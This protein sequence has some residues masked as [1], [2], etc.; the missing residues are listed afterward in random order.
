M[1]L[2][3]MNQCGPNDVVSKG[4]YKRD[5]ILGRL[6]ENTLTQAFWHDAILTLLV[7]I[8]WTHFRSSCKCHR[9]DFGDYT[10]YMEWWGPMIGDKRQLV[11][12]EPVEFEKHR[13]KF[14]TARK[15]PI[16]L[17]EFIEYTQFNKRKP[18]DVNMSPVGL[19]N[20]RI[21]TGYAQ[22]PPRSLVRTCLWNPWLALLVYSWMP[23]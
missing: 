2:F 13:L 7:S 17:E 23:R 19:A 5:H 4:A 3:I 20:T 11:T 15:L 9:L 6:I 10:G 1:V 14:K 8:F 22:K 12:N 18:E 21:S 16:I